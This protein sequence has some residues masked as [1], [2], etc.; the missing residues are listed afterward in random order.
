MLVETDDWIGKAG[1][2]NVQPIQ[3]IHRGLD[4][5][6]SFHRKEEDGAFV[7]LWSV[8]AEDLRMM[9]PQLVADLLN[10]SFFSINSFYRGGFG[11]SQLRGLPRAH[12][13]TKDLRYLNACFSDLDAY[14]EAGIQDGH[15]I[16]QL[17]I[18]QDQAVIPPA[19]LIVRSGQGSWCL[20][21]LRDRK[22]ADN[23]PVAAFTE[24]LILWNEIQRA[25]AQRLRN[26][27]PDALDAARV[28]RVPGS[29][30][31]GVGRPVTYLI[32]KDAAGQPYLYTLDEM[33][34]FLD[35]KLPEY[36]P[37]VKD[38]LTDKQ[39][40]P[41]NRWR[42]HRALYAQR[43]RDFELLQSIRGGF[44]EGCRNRA[45]LLSASFLRKSK[46][47]E[48]EIREHV[49]KFA[50]QCRPALSEA[51]A[52]AALREA[53]KSDTLR[54]IRDT[55]VGSWLRITPEENE[56]LEGTR[57][58]EPEIK[59]ETKANRVIRM[60]GRREA[61]LRIQEELGYTP[62]VRKMAILLAEKGH[63]GSHVTV[64]RDYKALGLKS[65]TA[66]KK[67]L[68][69]HSRLQQRAFV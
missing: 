8:K 3:L 28:M 52:L 15:L 42:G 22:S 11:K 45:C 67:E 59:L 5:Y 34:K 58:L 12:R 47:S 35:V 37:T 25:I 48:R 54:K 46:V 39:K 56:Q 27:G 31:T 2:P 33:A 9:F 29:I 6:V 32:Q 49:L 19:S 65:N 38:A 43:V 4:S 14:K 40:Q 60:E 68:R 13:Q 30:H 64:S 69:Q 50:K 10:D 41:G 66:Q 17:I 24:K 44:K 7:N 21:L 36:H 53:M 20:W 18:Y 63:Q 23:R 62:T 57:Y 61:I 1:G 26:L 51:E 55:T 16:G